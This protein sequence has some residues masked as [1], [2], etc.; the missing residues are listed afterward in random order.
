MKLIKSWR[1]FGNHD[2]VKLSW[3][4]QMGIEEVV[5]ALHHIPNGEVWSKEEI[6]KRKQQ[7]EAEGLRWSI[8]E[9]LPV[10]EE[11]KTASSL[12]DQ[13]IENYKTSLQNL[14]QCGIK[15][16]VYNFMPVIDWIRT[17]LKYKLASGGES[18]FFDY[19]AFAAFDLF[20]LKR[21]GA[22]QDYPDEIRAKAGLYFN[23]LGKDEAEQLGY[24]II[25]V[26]QG[27]VDGV[28]DAS[29]EN[30]RQAFLDHLDRYKHIGRN[31]LRENLSYFLKEVVPVAEAI[32]IN[33]AIHPDDPPFP[34]LG[35]PRIFSTAE[36][37]DWLQKTVP[38]LH[39]GI[40][41]CSGSFSAGKDN[42]LVE[43][44]RRYG[45]RIHFVHLRNTFILDDGKSFYESGHIEGRVN[46]IQLLGTIRHEMKMRKAAGRIDYNIP[47]R[48]DHGIK[49]ADDLGLN[50]NPGY[51]LLGRFKGLNEVAGMEQVLRYLDHDEI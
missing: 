46:M 1:W 20:I 31:E 8:V 45:E 21:P 26:T 27:F 28:I 15:T 3:L 40:A 36:D 13:H 23:N 48:P 19:T 39:N 14:A 37:M 5:T 4:P 50:A 33:L 18:M 41:F 44:F 22:L 47:F 29:T 11:I 35:L 38:S 43:M 6:L 30:Y 7:I 49:I 42:D 32:G 34:V 17:D 16:V 24:N 25:V 12:R 51:P 2:E 9:S 10:T